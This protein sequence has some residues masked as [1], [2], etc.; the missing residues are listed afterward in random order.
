MGDKGKWAQLLGYQTKVDEADG[1]DRFINL[2]S[3]F[4]PLDKLIF[5]KQ[6]LLA[7]IE[8]IVE[9]LA[10]Q[11]STHDLISTILPK[12]FTIFTQKFILAL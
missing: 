10:H 5:I 9:I 4:I 3:I 6:G 1:T 12:K 2:F 8:M 11:Q 7:L